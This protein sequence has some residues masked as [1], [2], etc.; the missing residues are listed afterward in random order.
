MSN[1][2][3]DL[4]LL[5]TFV[6]VVDSGGFTRAGARLY[7]SQSTISQQIKRLEQQIGKPLLAR[8][9]RNLEIT[10]AGETLLGYARRILALDDEARATLVR[11]EVEEVIRIGVSED[12]ASRHLAK[13]LAKFGRKHP[14]VRL[15]I[16]ADLSANLQQ[17]YDTGDLDVALLK[18]EEAPADAERK[19]RE[20]LCWVGAK[21]APLPPLEPAPLALFPQGCI[22]RRRAL[23]L[24]DTNKLAWR[25][26]FMSPSLA[27]LQ[28]AVAAGMAISPLST[29]A[30]S[31]DL[32]VLDHRALG[33]PNLG[34]VWFSLVSRDGSERRE[35]LCEAIATQ[36]GARV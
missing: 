24:L 25:I 7:R 27:G 5:R 22:Y 14:E 19:W 6:G 26:A 32:Q 3:L 4:D 10:D 21:S 28:A 29:S 12:F 15:D 36:V 1:R 11:G 33:L 30:L 13:V 31:R 18:S 34:P 16:R 17:A 20:K 23:E 9:G 35:Q 8:D 2:S